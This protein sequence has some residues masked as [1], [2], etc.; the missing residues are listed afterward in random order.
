MERALELSKQVAMEKHKAKMKETA[1]KP[2][3]KDDDEDIVD[4]SCSDEHPPKPMFAHVG[5][6]VRKKEERKKLFG[7]DCRE[8]QEY[9]QQKL[10][11]GQS[12]DQIMKILNKCSR[13]RGLFKPPRTPEKFWVADIVE[14][15]PNDP[16]N[17][18]QS[19][20]VFRTRA[21]RREEARSKRKAFM[22]DN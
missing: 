12:K 14:D 6:V 1:L 17:K 20:Q 16:R 7:F 18:K 19:G 8:C 22:S 3:K 15:D 9:Y 13:H 4:V 10:E 11:E 5:P 21:V 2:D